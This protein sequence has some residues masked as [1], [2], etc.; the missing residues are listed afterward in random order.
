MPA[1]HVYA[2][3]SE[4]D[5]GGAFGH[6]SGSIAPVVWQTNGERRIPALAGAAAIMLAGS[7]IVLGSRLTETPMDSRWD[8]GQLTV[9]VAFFLAVTLALAAGALITR[10]PVSVFAVA[11]LIAPGFL[12]LGPWLA[13]LV[14]GLSAFSIGRSA[15]RVFDR[16][17]L[18]FV[19]A[20]IALVVGLAVVSTTVQLTAGLAVHTPV[21]YALAAMACI[22][23]GAATGSLRDLATL[24]ASQET[25][26]ARNVAE[27]AAA[28]LAGACAIVLA[29]YARTPIVDNDSLILHLR[30]AEMMQDYGFYR[31]D[32]QTQGHRAAATD[33][34][35]GVGGVISGEYGAK[36]L[37]LSFALLCA[38]MVA[39]LLNNLAGRLAA[40]AGAAVLLASPI[41]YMESIGLFVENYLA[42]TVFAASIAAWRYVTSPTARNLLLCAFMVGVA[43]AVKLL[44]LLILPPIAAVLL[45]K[46]VG[47]RKW[48]HV[49]IGLGPGALVALLAAHW[50]YTLAWLDT[51]NPLFPLYNTIFKS[52][53]GAL[54][55]WVN[56]LYHHPLTLSG[57]VK[58]NFESGPWLEADGPAFAPFTLLT[59][60]TLVMAGLAAPKPFRSSLFAAS[61]AFFFLGAV[62]LFATALQQNYLRYFVPALP[63]LA[64]VFG[65]GF[66]LISVGPA[67]LRWIAVAALGGLLTYQ[68]ATAPGAFYFSRKM[69][70]LDAL[71]EQTLALRRDQAAP[72]R[73]LNEF[74]QLVVDADEPVL[75]FWRPYVAGSVP[76]A[77][78]VHPM[79]APFVWQSFEQARG[80]GA[81]EDWLQDT[82]ARWVVLNDNT[83]GALGPD[84]FNLLDKV[85]EPEL[86]IGEASIYQIADDAFFDRVE[87]A[88]PAAEGQ[89]DPWTISG[90][91]ERTADGVK[92]GGADLLVGTFAVQPQDIVLLEGEFACGTPEAAAWLHINWNDAVGKMILPDLRHHACEPGVTDFRMEFAAPDGAATAAVVMDAPGGQTMTFRRLVART[93]SGRQ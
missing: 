25:D 28:G 93:N 55:D 76:G 71:N 85:A 47:A 57:L 69:T 43:G 88:W 86:T 16:D 66:A 41:I 65:A 82:G 12:G 13:T 11:L 9:T 87:V 74:L 63:M 10:R 39:A 24:F 20:G 22:G 36:S 5:G 26:R 81:I 42:L 14:I 29:V 8:P 60:L 17:K 21:V 33:Y 48:R 53:D 77:V 70:P 90:A 75:Y 23:F 54:N 62:Y 35:Y 73:S 44:G 67:W 15:L 61:L 78:P 72:E 32:P 46:L 2:A 58:M 45:V 6:M 37:N 4:V 38:A 56:P 18:D 7:A 31:F 91:P 49:A 80:S 30:V 27:S 40:L 51:G 84:L 59:L 1:P 64:V 92:V 83:K 52:P 19:G 3:R 68:V 34:L 50:P 89:P 79:Y